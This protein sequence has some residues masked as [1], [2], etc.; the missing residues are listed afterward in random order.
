MARDNYLDAEAEVAEILLSL[1]SLA[2]VCSGKCP[3]K[4]AGLA[5]KRE[6]LPSNV[7]PGT[8]EPGQ[9]APHLGYHQKKL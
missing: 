2:R 9:S 6:K 4:R 3:T 8:N 1:L 7:S 5:L